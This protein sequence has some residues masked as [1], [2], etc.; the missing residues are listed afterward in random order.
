MSKALRATL[1][2]WRTVARKIADVQSRVIL[3]LM[4]FVVMAPFALPIRLFR[5]PLELRRAPGWHPLP[6]DGESTP[7]VTAA[8]Q[9]F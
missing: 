2:A 1:E 8:R 9:Q 4:Y 7:A 5:D 3:A 6:P